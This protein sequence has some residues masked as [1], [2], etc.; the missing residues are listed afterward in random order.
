MMFSPFCRFVL[1]PSN[2]TTIL[3]AQVNDEFDV[4]I[5]R[6]GAPDFTRKMLGE[7][8]EADCVISIT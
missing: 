3:E 5:Q 8:P 7:Y 6:T 2:G 1:I 4:M